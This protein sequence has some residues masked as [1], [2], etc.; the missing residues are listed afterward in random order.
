MKEITTV[1]SINS[2]RSFTGVKMES[3][4]DRPNS[5]KLFDIILCNENDYA[6][7]THIYFTGRKFYIFTAN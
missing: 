1:T 6:E 3:I 5:A 7:Q 2:F 4:K